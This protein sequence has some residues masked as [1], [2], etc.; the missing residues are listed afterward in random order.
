[1]SIDLGLPVVVDPSTAGRPGGPFAPR[2][3]S[4]WIVVVSW[5]PYPRRSLVRSATRP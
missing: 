5:L 1:M 2:K 3:I 4:G